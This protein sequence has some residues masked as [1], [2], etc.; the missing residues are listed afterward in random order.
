MQHPWL[1]CQS[2][3]ADL[4]EE[5]AARIAELEPPS[6]DP[7]TLEELREMNGEPVFIK[8]VFGRMW[9]LVEVSKAVSGRVYLHTVNEHRR[10]SQYEFTSWAKAG[11]LA[12]Y[13]RK[14]EEGTGWQQ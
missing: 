14:P 5:Q 4:I 6:N 12:V 3:C 8:S 13:R 11:G 10:M 1:R 2:G 9:A 7:L